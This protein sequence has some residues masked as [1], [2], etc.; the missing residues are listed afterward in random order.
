[1]KLRGPVAWM[2]KNTV[3][4]NLLMMVI[5]VAGALGSTQIKQEVFPAFELDIVTASVAYPGASPEEVEQGIVLAIEEA[6]RGVDGIKRVGG[7]SNEGI[8][9]VWAELLIE[10]DRDQAI[11]DIKSEVDRIQSFPEHWSESSP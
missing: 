2:A 8:G 11:A 4:A 6:V 1:M 5:I 3:A 9:T 10:T 7:S